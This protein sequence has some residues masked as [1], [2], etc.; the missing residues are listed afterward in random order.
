MGRRETAPQVWQYELVVGQVHEQRQQYG[1]EEHGRDA[2]G[3]LD[4]RQ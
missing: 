2:R 4:A 3:K 1:V